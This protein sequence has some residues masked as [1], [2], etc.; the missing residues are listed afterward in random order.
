MFMLDVQHCKK[1]KKADNELPD[2]MLSHSDNS[3]FVTIPRLRGL[4][5]TFSS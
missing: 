3:Y 2:R 1:K 5:Q 4:F